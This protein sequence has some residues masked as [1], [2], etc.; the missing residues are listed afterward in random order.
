LLKHKPDGE[1]Y[2]FGKMDAALQESVVGLRFNVNVN[3]R[4]AK[5]ED[6]KNIRRNEIEAKYFDERGTQLLNM[7]EASKSSHLIF[8]QRLTH[9][10]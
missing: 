3:S 5:D 1:P 10:F 9:M 2:Q 4:R 8:Y 7:N 6:G